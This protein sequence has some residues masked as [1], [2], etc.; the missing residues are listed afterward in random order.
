MTV[1]FNVILPCSM[2]DVSLV[3]FFII[4]AARPDY[5]EVNSNHRCVPTFY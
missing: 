4:I 5:V 1:R 2:D 3:T